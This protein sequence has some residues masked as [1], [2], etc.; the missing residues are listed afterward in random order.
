MILMILIPSTHWS[1][2]TWQVVLALDCASISGAPSATLTGLES[3]AV[4]HQAHQVNGKFQD[5]KM[6]LLYYIVL[7]KA[8][9]WGYVP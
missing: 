7:Y 8:I 6:E 9:F 4:L 5:P 2:E 3:Q 1:S